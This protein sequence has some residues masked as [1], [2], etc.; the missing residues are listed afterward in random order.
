MQK[1]ARILLADD[2]DAVRRG[3]RA[4]LHPRWNVVGEA[5]NGRHAVEQ[6]RAVKPDVVLLDLMMPE[7]NGLDAARQILEERPST[8]VLLLTMQPSEELTA[9]ARRAG[10]HAVVLKSDADKLARLLADIEHDTPHLC[11]QAI[12]S[13]HI[14]AFFTSES[15]RLR[16]LTPFFEEG[17]ARGEKAVWI[18]KEE[19][20]RRPANRDA[21]TRGAIQFKTWDQ[22]YLAD[23]QFDQYA[24]LDRLGAELRSGG[25]E[26]FPRTRLMADMEWAL[27]ALPGVADLAEYESR[28]NDRIAT[29]ADII[30]CSYDLNRFSGRVIVDVLRAHPAIIVGGCLL[31]NPLYVPTE[32]LLREL[33]T[34]SA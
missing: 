20:E 29:P 33:A 26:G 10:I 19:A 34:E 22:M 1:A 18:V 16:V 5:S 9:E 6:A 32:Q 28:I 25:E 24:M 11:G 30:V 4:I 12:H 27:E 3:L 13:R 15:E 14:G 31:D 21:T 17:L 8:H 23:R 7:L 2:H